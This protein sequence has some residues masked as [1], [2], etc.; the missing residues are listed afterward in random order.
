M[1]ICN[2]S[3]Y[4]YDTEAD[5]RTT[6]SLR[7]LSLREEFDLEAIFNAAKD[8]IDAEDLLERIRRLVYNPVESDCANMKYI[9]FKVIDTYGRTNY[10]KFKKAKD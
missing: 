4:H 7:D 8:A 1:D 6:I 3:Y 5:K 10:L 9:R 2:I